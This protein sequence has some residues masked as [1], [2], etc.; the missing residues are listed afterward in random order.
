MAVTDVIYCPQRASK[1]GWEGGGLLGPVTCLSEV[2]GCLISVCEIRQVIYV[3]LCGLKKYPD[4]RISYG[5]HEQLIFD[6]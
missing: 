4:L 3:S 5:L 1:W 6:P 2:L